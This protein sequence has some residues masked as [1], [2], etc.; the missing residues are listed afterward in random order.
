MTPTPKGEAARPGGVGHRQGL[1]GQRDR[2]ASLN[3][4]HGRAEAD[5]GHL[6]RGHGERGE[7][8]EPGG[9]GKPDRPEAFGQPPPP[10]AATTASTVVVSAPPHTETAI[11]TGPPE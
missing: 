4:D 1:L 9:L 5:P 3:G 10:P 11:T 8:V 7:R 2:M 6:D